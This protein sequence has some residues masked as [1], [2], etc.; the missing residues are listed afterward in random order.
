VNIY[1]YR[2]E[3]LT[4]CEWGSVPDTTERN[5]LSGRT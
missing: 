1:S 2:V 4:G 5:W 3:D